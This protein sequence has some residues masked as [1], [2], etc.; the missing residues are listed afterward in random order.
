MPELAQSQYT[1]YEC[2]HCECYIVRP[3]RILFSVV[4][5]AVLGLDQRGV[6]QQDGGGGVAEE[7]QHVEGGKGGSCALSGAPAEVE[8]WLEVEGGGPRE[9]AGNCQEGFADSDWRLRGNVTI[10]SQLDCWWSAR[11]VRSKEREGIYREI[12]LRN[13]ICDSVNRERAVN[14]PA[15]SR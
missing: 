14:S 3:D 6:I 7:A 1:Q 8:E 9:G 12:A 15:S 10:S 11:I 2:V 5:G 13:W 4:A